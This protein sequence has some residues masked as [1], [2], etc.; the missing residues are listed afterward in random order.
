MTL[1][2]KHRPQTIAELDS[3]KVREYFT[4]LFTAK[5]EAIDIPL[6]ELVSSLVKQCRDKE[7]IR[8]QRERVLSELAT[9]LAIWDIINQAE[10]LTET[11]RLF[12]QYL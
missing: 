10:I 2:N 3:R 5:I 9:C 8:K 11:A 1:Y 12:D 7:E 4:D 6:E